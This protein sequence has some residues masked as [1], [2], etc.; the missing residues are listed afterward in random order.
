MNIHMRSSISKAVLLFLIFLLI[1]S[2][3][4]SHRVSQ[5]RTT[6]PSASS[7]RITAFDNEGVESGVLTSKITT[8]KESKGSNFTYTLKVTEAENW[9]R[10]YLKLNFST[11]QYMAN[12][13]KGG[14]LPNALTYYSSYSPG[15][16]IIVIV[17]PGENPAKVS[18]SGVI[19]TIII[20]P[21][22]SE[23]I[24]STQATDDPVV[25]DVTE[26]DIGGQKYLEWNEVLR[27][28][29]NQNH[30]VDFP[31]FG[32]IGAKYSQIPKSTEAPID[33]NLNGKIEFSDFGEIGMRYNRTVPGFII[34]SSFKGSYYLAKRYALKTGV[35]SSAEILTPT[36]KSAQ[37]WHHYKSPINWTSDSNSL[38][39]LNL[40]LG[41]LNY[42]SAVI[43]SAGGSL[44]APDFSLEVPAGA[45]ESD[46][47][48]EFQVE[49][50]HLAML[51]SMCSTPYSI[52]GLPDK[53]LKPITVTFKYRS[54]SNK[55]IVGNKLITIQEPVR[56]L[57][58]HEFNWSYGYHQLEVTQNGDQLS[59]II[60]ASSPETGKTTSTN[61]TT[62][63]VKD[64][65]S[66]WAIAGYYAIESS[67]K[68]FRITY[69]AS[70]LIQ[71]GA[72]QIAAQ[73]EASYDKLVSYGFSWADRTRLPIE[74]NIQPVIGSDGSPT[75]RWG[76]YVPSIW[77][78]NHYSI[79]LNANNINNQ[80]EIDTM[81][82]SASHELFHLV[83]AMYD[84]RSWYSIAKNRGRW[85]WMDEASAVWFETQM[86][87]D[88][89]NYL[90]SV[91]KDN[92]NFLYN[93]SL[94]FYTGS[95]SEVESHGYGASIFLKYYTK[96]YGN[97]SICEL[98]KL[99]DKSTSYTPLDALESVSK[100]NM[101][102]D[103]SMFC[104]DYFSG[105]LYS[106]TVLPLGSRIKLSESF[107]VK[108]TLYNSDFFNTDNH[109]PGLSARLYVVNLANLNGIT[110]AKTSAYF[111]CNY[112]NPKD[113]NLTTTIYR[114]KNKPETVTQLGT[115]KKLGLNESNELIYDCEVSNIGDIADSDD[116]IYCLIANT[117]NDPTDIYFDLMTEICGP[118]TSTSGTISSFG[119][120]QKTTSYYHDWLKLDPLVT[121]KDFTSGAM[122][123]DYEAPT[124]TWID[125]L[126][127]K[128]LVDTANGKK[129]CEGVLSA[130]KRMLQW[131][132]MEEHILSYNPQQ[133]RKLEATNVPMVAKKRFDSN[134]IPNLFLYRIDKYT[135]DVMYF[136]VYNRLGAD[137]QFNHEETIWENYNFKDASVQVQFVIPYK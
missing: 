69:P 95:D 55:P 92:S 80:T 50:Q 8:I 7:L 96:K 15:E 36:S 4:S 47:K 130:D 63:A 134:Y 54:I 43:G 62:S 30:I 1:S 27:G 106:A 17:N 93:N 51:D 57:D 99:H 135:P 126:H 84:A 122:S 86:S 75:S 88:P 9:S 87:P 110:P 52:K 56:P 132:K 53:L 97:T 13:T 39:D 59:A 79:N 100:Y 42:R 23:S 35:D 24:K 66:M 117:S 34:Y 137:A 26:T 18:G 21:G 16:A 114:V 101:F 103:W 64:S 70:D 81:K 38:V 136:Y 28:D 48:L 113:Y 109:S 127:F 29:C 78:I 5:S 123:V 45:F 14:F 77:G 125:D 61:R 46:N 11:D 91:A 68:H 89:N 31:D 37:G 119:Y 25:Q 108:S 120:T 131:F 112:P 6:E 72:E 71:G 20:A 121:S 104:Q 118:S 67:N 41:A 102:L 19:G 124:F 65:F 105:K 83:Q 98:Y 82:L 107:I 60:P 115:L 73:L 2:S 44:V 12:F 32:V 58:V 33:P 40:N 129:Y 94:D 74:I 111:T 3:C 128:Y 116:G 76:E 22:E 10:I 90:A 85:Y 49:T 133:W